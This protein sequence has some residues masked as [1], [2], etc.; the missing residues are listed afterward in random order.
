MSMTS[1]QPKS[2]LTDNSTHKDNNCKDSNNNKWAP[3]CSQVRAIQG[4]ARSADC[5]VEASANNNNNNN[6]YR[7]SGSVVCPMKRIEFDIVWF[8]LSNIK[9]SGI[10]SDDVI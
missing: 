8:L 2:Y 3:L 9:T 1:T 4:R 10:D 5:I 7:S 6:H